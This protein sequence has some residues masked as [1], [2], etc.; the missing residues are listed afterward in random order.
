S[1]L[2]DWRKGYDVFIQVARY[3]KKQ[4]PELDIQF[5]WVGSI[6]KTNRIIIEEDLL[7]LGLKETVSFVEELSNPYNVYNSF[8]VFLMCSREDPFPLVCIEMGMLLKP[9]I[10][11][12]KATGTAEI[13]SKGGGEI[14]AYL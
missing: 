4:R 9:I 13:I 1:G 2:V 6:S 14:V 10:C 8:D 3:I 11:F 7:K 5:T 12:E